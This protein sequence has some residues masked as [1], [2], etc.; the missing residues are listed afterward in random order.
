MISQKCLLDWKRE[1]AQW[2]MAFATQSEDLSTIPSI[3]MV[4]GEKQ[5]LHMLLRRLHVL[6]G[7]QLHT[8]SKT[9]KINL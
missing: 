5:L 6:H 9:I 8:I 1:L 7:I 4:E 2:I 3:H